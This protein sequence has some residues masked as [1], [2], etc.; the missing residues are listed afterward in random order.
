MLYESALLE[1]ILS[2]IDG[3][4][5]LFSLPTFSSNRKINEEFTVELAGGYN[6]IVLDQYVW[7]RD[8]KN[9]ML[10]ILS[11]PIHSCILPA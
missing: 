6:V 4:N 9:D 10:K 2:D 8:L 1:I 7:I 3:K 5:I 11:V